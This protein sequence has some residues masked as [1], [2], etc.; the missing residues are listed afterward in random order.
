MQQLAAA[1]EPLLAAMGMVVV[2]LASR[3]HVS[4]LLLNWRNRHACDISGGFWECDEPHNSI[5]SMV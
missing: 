5:F 3:L 2:L 1:A 4:D